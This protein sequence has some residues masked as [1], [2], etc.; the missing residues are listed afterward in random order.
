LTTIKDL[1]KAAG[2]SITTVSR[3]LNGYDDVSRET[4]EKISK[5]AK[6]MNYR[7]NAAAR[8]L[9]TKKS[10][11]LG[12]ILSEIKR[13]GAKDSVAFEILCGIN[14]R[15]AELNYD[16]LLF[17]TNPKKQLAKSYSDLCRE[18]NVEGAI[19]SG[20]RIQDQY[21]HEIVDNVDF[22]SVLIDIPLSGKL[23][24]HVTTNNL[25]GALIAVEH[26]LE[27]GHRN[28]AMINGHNEASISEER[29]AGYTQALKK[30]NI[31]FRPEWVYNGNFTEEGGMEAMY[32]IML[33]H[34]DVTAVF[35]ASDLMALGALRAAERLGKKVPESISLVGFDDIPLASYC[36]PR[37]T[38]IRQDRYEMGYQA[39]QLLIDILEDRKVNR[40]I[41][42]SNELIARE[43]TMRL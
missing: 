10:R 39:A 22:P 37:F 20:L 36:S 29:L 12:V 2:V 18:R 7:P 17:S 42:L 15:A 34:P 41:V 3:A 11:T 30:R 19:I 1:A 14:D 13:S 21:L 27:L 16:I 40:K 25:H 8:S 28:I 9:V 4:R 24:G 31:A 32:Q 5:I 43:S 26:L 35:S 6:E 23:L 33:N 38:T